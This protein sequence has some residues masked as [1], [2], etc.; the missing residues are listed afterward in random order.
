MPK[1]DA[2]Q[3]Y[4]SPYAAIIPNFISGALHNSDLNIYGTGEQTRDFIHVSDAIDAHLLADKHTVTGSFNVGTGRS[5]SILTIAQLVQSLE[6]RGK[7]VFSEPRPGDA[8]SS[9]ADITKIARLLAFTPKIYVENGIKELYYHHKKQ[10][11]Q[12]SVS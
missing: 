1:W 10:L 11:T 6:G 7:I 12:S 4:D 2:H 5:T 3:R 8:A 9:C